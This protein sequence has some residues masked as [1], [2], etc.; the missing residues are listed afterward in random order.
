MENASSKPMRVV[1]SAKSMAYAVSPHGAAHRVRWDAQM[2]NENQLRVALDFHGAV[3]CLLTGLLRKAQPSELWDVDRFTFLRLE[4]PEPD[5]PRGPIR[6]LIAN[7]IPETP[8][9]HP[10]KGPRERPAQIIVFLPHI[11]FDF[12]LAD[13]YSPHQKTKLAG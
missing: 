9:V 8:L 10:Q 3:K 4:E 5:R 2:P 11:P 12:K 6:L 13:I 7:F 1:L